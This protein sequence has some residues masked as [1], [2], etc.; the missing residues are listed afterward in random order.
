MT[1][2]NDGS[3]D[4]PASPLRPDVMA[5]VTKAV[6]SALSGPDHRALDVGGGDGQ[7]VLPRARRAGLRRGGALHEVVGRLRHG[8]NERAPVDA[9]DGALAHWDVLLTE[10]AK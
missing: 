1:R 5:A 9:I 4:A 7:H 10:L 6:H 3:I 8:L 2:Q